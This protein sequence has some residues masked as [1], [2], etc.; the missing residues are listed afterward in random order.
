[1]KLFKALGETAKRRDNSPVE[2]LAYSRVHQ[3]IE[4]LCKLYLKE[5]GDIFVFEALPESLDAALTCLESK[6]FLDKYNFNQISDTC[7]EVSEK[8]IDIFG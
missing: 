6:D 5:T 8:V 2:R 3:A 7:F 4:E 1:M